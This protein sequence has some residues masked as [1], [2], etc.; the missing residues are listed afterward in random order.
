MTP[1]KQTD[2]FEGKNQS[3]SKKEMKSKRIAK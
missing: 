2:E 1:K 3:Q